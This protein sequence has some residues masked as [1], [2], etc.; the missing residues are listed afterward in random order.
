MTLNKKLLTREEWSTF[1]LHW[2]YSVPEASRGL[3][4]ILDAIIQKMARRT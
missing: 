3:D 2:I 1:G 4:G